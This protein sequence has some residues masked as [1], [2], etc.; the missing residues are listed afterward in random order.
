MI[1]IKILDKKYKI[2]AVDEL[3]TAEYIELMKIEQ[4]DIVKYIAWQTGI[5]TDSAF[6]A[7]TN[8]T[9]EKSIGRLK[10]VELMDRSP[11]FD[12]SKKIDTVGQRH[13][14]EACRKDG[15]ELLVYCLAVAQ[16][17]SNNHE[18]VDKF[19]TKYMDSLYSDILPSGFF[20]YKNLQNG[21][22]SVIGRLRMR[23]YLIRT[24]SRRKRQGFKG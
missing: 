15:Y 24:R 22:Q 3:T 16:A 21:R 7:V 18:D 9:L 13:Q 1:P 6:Y 20:F 4:L 14:L 8:K 11:K 2:K 17:R 10:P 12:Y 5:D 19:Y 23:L